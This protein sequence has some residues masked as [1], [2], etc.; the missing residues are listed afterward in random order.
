LRK[1]VKEMANQST[2]LKAQVEGFLVEDVR[3]K[4]FTFDVVDDNGVITLKGTVDSEEA[5]QAAAEIVRERT[6]AVEVINDIELQS[7]EDPDVM[8][9]VPPNQLSGQ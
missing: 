6:D 2:D 5:C 3:T 9:P 1:G 4:D 7:D 8:R